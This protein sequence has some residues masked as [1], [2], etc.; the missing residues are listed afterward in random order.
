MSDSTLA[1]ADL[2]LG[3]ASRSVHAGERAPRPAFTPTSTPIYLSNSFSYGDT[4]ALEDAFQH[5]RTSFV[6]G[7]HG[8]PSVRAL[9]HAIASLEQ[10]DDVL[11]VGSGMAALHVAILNEVQAGSKIVASS[12]LYGATSALLT[13]LFATLGVKT[14]FADASDLDAFRAVVAE[15][16]PRVVLVETISNPLV[17]VADIAGIAEIAREHWT[18]L[19]VDNTFASPYLVNPLT[20]GAKT[21]VH[22]ATK[23]LSGHGDVTGGAIASDEARIGDICEV[24]KLGGAILGP[25]EAWLTLRGIKTLPLRMKQQCENALAIARWLERHP[26]VAKVNYPGLRD[27]GPAEGQF[28]NPG[29]G[30]MLSFDIRDAG[31]DEVFAFLKAL[32]LVQSAITL[33][34]VYT[35]ALYPAMSSHRALTPEQRAAAGIGDGLVRLSAGIEDVEDVIEDLERAL[36]S[37][38]T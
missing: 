3:F 27:L 1:N 6:Y 13:N 21:V 28:N 29:R 26:R 11:A 14:T 17:R 35:L 31:R 8:N 34:D 25:F 16:K 30:G 19:I 22:S 12:D 37:V 9:E 32:R 10:A 36:C 20:F 33:G 2:H 7:R 23:Y 4:D 15:V 5:D 38:P 24:N 18:R